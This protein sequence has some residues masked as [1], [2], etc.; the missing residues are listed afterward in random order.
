MSVHVNKDIFAPYCLLQLTLLGC[1]QTFFVKEN[2]IANIPHHDIKSRTHLFSTRF[3][4]NQ[5][6]SPL[7]VF[8]CQYKQFN[9][10]T[11]IYRH[12]QRNRAATKIMIIIEIIR[13]SLRLK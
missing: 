11:M 2:C 9:N 5:H 1:R 6:Q 4:Y 3:C 10:L 13:L 12:I 8:Q 7:V